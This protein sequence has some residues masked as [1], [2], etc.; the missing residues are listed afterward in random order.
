MPPD[1]PRSAVALGVA[2]RTVAAL[3]CFVALFGAIFWSPGLL[4]GLFALAFAAD[5][6]TLSHALERHRRRARMI[7]TARVARGGWLRSPARLD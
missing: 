3:T 7:H 2:V 4:L 1:A 6:Q 5:A